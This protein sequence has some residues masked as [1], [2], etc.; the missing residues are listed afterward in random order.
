MKVAFV[1]LGDPFTPGMLYKENYFIRAAL[2]SGDPALVLAGPRTWHKGQIVRISPE[3]PD[4]V[5]YS[6]VRVEGHRAIPDPL[7]DKVRFFPGVV[8]RLIEFGPDL[9]YFNTP[10]VHLIG[11]CGL[12][13]KMLPNVRLVASFTSTYD[14]SGRNA[15]SRWLQHRIMYR[16]WIQ[17]ALPYLDAVYCVS[18]E[19]RAFVS[20]MYGLRH[21]RLEVMSLPGEVVSDEDRRRRASEFRARRD[22]RPDATIVMHSGKMGPLKRTVDILRAFSELEDPG[23]RLVLA[24]SVS[25]EI[26]E[27]V[28]SAIARD[29]RVIPLGFVSSDELIQAMC[30]ATLYVQPGSVSH[31][32]QAA[33]C[34]GTPV[35]LAPHPIY[36]DLCSSSVPFVETVADIY[37]VMRMAVSRGD[38]LRRISAAVRMIAEDRLDYRTLYRRLRGDVVE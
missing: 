36:L 21:D 10:Q 7:N 32:A 1:C 26:S 38:E 37:S 25:D 13:K 3:T 8:D 11:Q 24:G 17:Q 2:E 19:T 33:M 15:A 18:D 28:D 12:L 16:R 14:N 9:I 6:L 27:S 20:D 35:A 22:I 31:S 29:A 30:A 23:A 34:C 4:S 5:G